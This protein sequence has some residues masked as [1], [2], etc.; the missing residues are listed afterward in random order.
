MDRLTV[1]D[2]NRRDGDDDAMKLQSMP[3]GMIFIACLVAVVLTI[4]LVPHRA[5]P[6]LQSPMHAS[7]N[8][9]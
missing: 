7:M 2:Q 3:F 8:R 1:H 4:S 6:G 5:F 9:Y